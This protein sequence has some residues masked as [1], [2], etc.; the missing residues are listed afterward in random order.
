MTADPN[1]SA[2][3]PLLLKSPEAAK[4]LSISERSLFT[5]AKTGRIR[6]IKVGTR[7][8]RY[9]FRDLVRFIDEQKEKAG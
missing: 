9:D 7:G 3:G 4:L 2:N 5:L 6:P 8:I 1:A